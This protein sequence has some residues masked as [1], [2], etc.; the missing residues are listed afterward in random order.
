MMP[1]SEKTDLFDFPLDRYPL[2]SGFAPR[3]IEHFEV[4]RIILAKGSL[5]T[6]QR[7]CFVRSICA[8]YPD[9]EIQEHLD[10]PHN[11]IDLKE[12]NPLSLHQ[13]GKRTLL[14]G[15]LKNAV[16][17]SEEEANTC[18]N[19]WHF[20]VYGFCPYG[21]KYCY[22]AGT[23][24]VW[25]SPT[26]KI[27]VNLPEILEMIDRTAR[28]LGRLV[29]FYHGKLQDGLA[30]DPLTAYSTVMIPF[31]ARHP[32]ARQVLLTK[33]AN[34]E[35]LLKL[36]HNGRTILSWSLNPPAIAERFE[37][38]VPSIEQRLEAMRR[39]ASAG[40]P[41]R[42]VIMPIIPHPDWQELYVEFIKKLIG[43]LPLQRLT[44]GGICIYRQA[45]QLMESQ[46]GGGNLISKSIASSGEK[47]DGRGRYDPVLRAR[48]YNQLITTA[49][50]IRPDLEL[51]LCLE[52]PAVWELVQLHGG[53]GRCNCVL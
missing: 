53:Q 22:L 24:G 34:V 21:C 35:R 52:E 48:I 42:A 9:A 46:L 29:A 3:P 31:F 4:C 5:D 10:T 40:Y 6:S 13:K 14:F 39:C 45:R 38:N 16:R 44:L 33:S 50:A 28:R 8:A 47:G 18:P 19:Y 23:Q 43:S 26:V 7:E 27:Y 36:E 15:E 12:T 20:S 37:R 41:L 32:I 30:L 11:R 25:F 49:R 51:A 2:P 17:L 1:Y